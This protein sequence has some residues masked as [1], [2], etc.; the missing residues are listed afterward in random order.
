[1]RYVSRR[2]L[3]VNGEKH[4]QRNN[5]FDAHSAARQSRSATARPIPH[6]SGKPTSFGFAPQPCEYR[7][8]ARVHSSPGPR[9]SRHQASCHGCQHQRNPAKAAIS[10]PPILRATTETGRKSTIVRN[11]DP[12]WTRSGRRLARKSQRTAISTAPPSQKTAC[13]EFP[14][15]RTTQAEREGHSPTLATSFP[16]EK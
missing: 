7:F 1:M 14:G 8:R 5:G 10:A 11:S 12:G 13:N 9:P 2:R 15:K 6:A 16:E 4:S 3:P